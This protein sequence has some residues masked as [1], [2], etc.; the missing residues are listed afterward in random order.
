EAVAR[1]ERRA[2]RHLLAPDVLQR[3]HG[4]HDERAV[5]EDRVDA[6]GA[7]VLPRLLVGA[8]GELARPPLPAEHRVLRELPLT[9]ERRLDA[10][11][12]GGRVQV[13]AIALGPD[14]V[15]GAAR[16][17]A[18]LP[19]VGEGAHGGAG[20]VVEDDAA[21]PRGRGDGPREEERQQDARDHRPRRHQWWTRSSTTSP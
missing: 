1:L 6:D 12:A 3:L 11:G 4:P 9:L 16:L 14:R 5:G 21:V 18:D 17:L 2:L 8:P 13:P 7:V 15:D 10:E 19:S 20:E